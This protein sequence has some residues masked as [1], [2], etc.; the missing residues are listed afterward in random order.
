[1]KSEYVKKIK[2]P[3]ECENVEKCW[4]IASFEI[5]DNKIIF[6]EKLGILVCPGG[7]DYFLV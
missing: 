2:I 4:A 7:N 5:P 6:M 1:M 3:S